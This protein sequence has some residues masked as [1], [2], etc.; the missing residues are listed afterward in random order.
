MHGVFP[1][2]SEDSCGG[3][4]GPGASTSMAESPFFEFFGAKGHSPDSKSAYVDENFKAFR[5]KHGKNY[6]T[7]KEELWRKQH[8]HHNFRLVT[9]QHMQCAYMYCVCL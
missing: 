5:A 2:H 8:F 1:L 3:F 6:E 4:P 9:T 7:E